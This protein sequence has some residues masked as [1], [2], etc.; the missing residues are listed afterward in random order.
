MNP[1]QLLA[2]PLPKAGGGLAVYY[3]PRLRA[4]GSLDDWPEWA[5][6]PATLAGLTISAQL[7]NASGFIQNVPLGAPTTAP[8]SV[9]WEALF[10]N[11]ANLDV[12]FY[13]FVDRTLQQVQSWSSSAA[14]DLLE[15]FYKQLANSFPSAVPGAADIPATALNNVVAAGNEFR[16]Y[17]ASMR[18]D[19]SAVPSAPS[20]VERWG[21]HDIV[22][23]A[24][25]HPH[26]MR[27][28]GLVTDHAVNIPA[29]IGSG[30]SAGPPTRIRI[31]TDYNTVAAQREQ[32]RVA[33]VLKDGAPAAANDGPFELTDDG[34]LQASEWRL[35]TLD[36]RAGL[37]QMVAWRKSLDPDSNALPLPPATGISV[38]LNDSANAAESRFDAMTARHRAV[39]QAVLALGVG[40]EVPLYRDDVVAGLRFDVLDLDKPGAGYLSLFERRP[41]P[42]ADGS[43]Y[44]FEGTS[45]VV[46][47][48][49]DDEGW[50][51]P[52]V[53]SEDAET[54]IRPPNNLNDAE[55]QFYQPNANVRFSPLL[56]RWDGWS[57][58]APRPGNVIDNAGNVVPPDSNEPG[59]IPGIRQ[60][61]VNYMPVPA[62]LPQLRYGHTYRLRARVVDIAGNSQPVSATAPRSAE[63]AN[64]VFGRTDPVSAPIP[65]RVQDKPVPGHREALDT[66]VI[67]SELGDSDGAIAEDT[68]TFYPP[69]A[70]QGTL[71]RH[72][73]PG[74]GDDAASYNLLATRD[75]LSVDDQTTSDPVSG[76]RIS[77]GNELQPAADYFPDPAASGTTFSGLPGSS[78]PV[79]SPIEGTWPNRRAA[80]LEMVSG[81]AAPAV[82]PTG[83]ISVRVFVP[84]AVVALVDVSMSLEDRTDFFLDGDASGVVQS[85]LTAGRQWMA[86][87]RLPLRL[88]HATRLPLT[89]PV[90]LGLSATRPLL[91][92][93]DG[94][95]LSP[96]LGSLEALISLDVKVDAHSTARA[97]CLAKWTDP[98][99]LGPGEAAPATTNIEG[100]AGTRTRVGEFG[101]I[102][103]TYNDAD[104]VVSG[105]DLVLQMRD[106]KAHDVFVTV[107]AFSRFS[108]FF[109]EQVE[110]DID[111]ANKP[112][113]IKSQRLPR[114]GTVQEGISTG[115]VTVRTGAGTLVDPTDYTI[116]RD[117]GTITPVAGGALEN[118]SEARVNFV[119]LPVS[120]L[121]TGLTPGDPSTPTISP[122]RVVVPASRR[123]SLPELFEV[124]PSVARDIREQ[125]GTIRIRHN[126]QV[127]RFFLERPWW[128]SGRNELFAA[129]LDGDTDNTLMGRDPIWNG[130]GIQAP[131]EEDEW[132]RAAERGTFDGLDVVGH[133]VRWDG[134]AEKWVA[135][136]EIAADFGYRPFVRPVVCRFQPDAIGGAHLSERVLVDP[137]RLGV[138]REVQIRPGQSSVAITV[139]GPDNDGT[140]LLGQTYR[141]EIDAYLQVAQPEVTDPDLTWMTLSDTTVRLQRIERGDGWTNWRTKLTF[142]D[143]N[144]TYRLVLEETEPGR[145]ETAFGLNSIQR[146]TV[147]VETVEL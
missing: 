72:G 49:P 8:S 106:A 50:V 53:T 70:N 137:H 60:V 128:T 42:E 55:T 127:L 13:Q 47:S 107:E 22:G 145:S 136:I 94:V 121:S 87:G 2:I 104:G 120:R 61:G 141:N 45:E 76:E 147:F 62:T 59:T 11:P 133:E 75:A 138:Q 73:V 4:N 117:A 66:M 21:F 143:P 122:A 25:S 23:M 15:A 125:D 39:E 18:P 78:G 142:P 81:K 146:T 63:S 116:D 93:D 67:L 130:S 38:L 10:G 12:Y 113:E 30:G 89:L 9:V 101:A 140:V 27:L 91:T 41:I 44:R 48:V 96:G 52:T 135:D 115:S 56:F 119:A 29:N 126:G 131:M 1:A 74:D 77:G 5:D 57:G 40:D 16:T 80:S 7:E 32:I 114:A 118:A 92:D 111:G 26:L 103:V 65:A 85:A 43:H 95:V 124:I 34:W 20:T 105:S 109:T 71:E 51:V 110:V 54:A 139:T 102:P 123:P 36:H 28:L 33:M 97:T 37:H 14:A 86:S 83:N 69:S 82:N 90:P 24:Q 64:I 112:V 132:R 144:E 108:E 98:I 99:D 31:V 134:A 79:T 35:S 84:K 17:A 19:P 3:S 6:W 46:T 129:V 100:D 68:R 58:A 88:V